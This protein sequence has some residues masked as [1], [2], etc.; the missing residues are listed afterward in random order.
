VNVGQ[1]APAT[2]AAPQQR[3][4][5]D[6]PRPNR[7]HARDLL[8][9]FKRNGHEVYNSPQSNLGDALA[10]LNHLEDS[11]I[12][13]RLQAN[14]RVV[15]AQIEERGPGYSRFVASSYSR[16]RSERPHQRRRSQGPLD[17]VAEEGRGENKVMQPAN[18]SAN[19]AAN[20]PVN[21]AANAPANA[22]VNAV[23]NV[24][25]KQPTLPTSRG[26]PPQI[27]DSMQE[28]SLLRSR[29]IVRREVSVTA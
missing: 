10:A 1:Q 23:G 16:S 18:P 24:A 6:S 9:D 28:P 21:T 20:A 11:P 15:A 4:R 5:D 27:Q 29:P 17:L 12:I 26:T 19:A 2:P 3:C 7:L 8:K 13:R 22:P 14:I 25:N